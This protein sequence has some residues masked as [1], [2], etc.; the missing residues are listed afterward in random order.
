MCFKSIIFLAR[1]IFLLLV[2]S[3]VFSAGINITPPLPN[4]SG[5]DDIK[6]T[7][8]NMLELY[9]FEKDASLPYYNNSWQLGLYGPRK[10]SNSPTQSWNTPFM[11][12][13]CSKV[14]DPKQFSLAT[15]GDYLSGFKFRQ[16]F[17]NS[18]S[19]DLHS[20]RQISQGPHYSFFSDSRDRLLSPGSMT[21]SGVSMRQL[22]QAL[23]YVPCNDKCTG[24]AN[25]PST[26]KVN[27]IFPW[28][29]LRESSWADNLEFKIKL[30]VGR[31]SGRVTSPLDDGKPGYTIKLVEGR[32]PNHVAL[33]ALPALVKY[34]GLTYSVVRR[35]ENDRDVRL[36]GLKFDGR[37]AFLNSG[38]VNYIKNNGGHAF[39]E[40]QLIYLLKDQ[41]P[42]DTASAS[43]PA[44]VKFENFIYSVICSGTSCATRDFK[45]VSGK[46]P[47]FID[48]LTGPAGV[49]PFISGK[50]FSLSDAQI[51]YIN[52][53]GGHLFSKANHS[54]PYIGGNIVYFH[55]PELKIGGTIY[56]ET[57]T[58]TMSQKIAQL[59]PHCIRAINF[60]YGA[61]I[62][63][64]RYDSNKMM[65]KQM[66]GTIPSIKRD[67]VK[68]AD[69]KQLNFDFQEPRFSNPKI[70]K[71]AD[72]DIA[73]DTSLNYADKSSGGEIYDFN[74]NKLTLPSEIINYTNK[75]YLVKNA[76]SYSMRGNDGVYD[77]QNE[78]KN[79][80]FKI[81]ITKPDFERMIEVAESFIE[82]PPDNLAAVIKRC[83][84]SVAIYN[85]NHPKE[86]LDYK[87][88]PT[89]K[90]E[91]G[92]YL[93]LDR[94]NIV[95]VNVGGEISSTE[96][97]GVPG[98]KFEKTYKYSPDDGSVDC[99]KTNPLPKG[100][101]KTPVP[102]RA[103]M[104]W[105]VRDISLKVCPKAGC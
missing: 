90:D 54:V 76:F 81:R 105:N 50:E 29:K 11:V 68:L 91:D 97:F 55:V 59:L 61:I 53:N 100:S 86:K 74:Y 27:K 60:S 96:N 30:D 99:V 82:N 1:F 95:S 10:E 103:Y 32:N 63:D 71:K 2:S 13:E 52:A 40:S 80:T 8:I 44:L 7:I 21:S 89:D 6:S 9:Q 41:R 25:L 48:S 12:Q 17:P 66:S 3:P 37:R 101:I 36:L 22:S 34:Q 84:E 56:A 28:K 72:G 26:L 24:T 85:D 35:G 45:R 70:Y 94:I 51:S 33:D 67:T 75:S 39:T 73:I 78:S 20:F 79:L 92:N 47:D 18:T 31:T 23:A 69:A 88:F 43:L 64:P 15:G 46:I 4:V 102:C 104:G 77:G 83:D 5:P 58:L 16:C 98:K 42:R 49:G 65:S 87:I 57:A 93:F 19:T 62:Y 14:D 38:Q